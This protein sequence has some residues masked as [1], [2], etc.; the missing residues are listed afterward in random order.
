MSGKVAGS[1]HQIAVRVQLQGLAQ[2]L[3][4]PCCPLHRCCG[5]SELASCLMVQVGR[6]M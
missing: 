2:L 3:H 6:R 5:R 1:A 4:Q